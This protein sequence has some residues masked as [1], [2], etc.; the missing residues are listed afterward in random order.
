MNRY[1]VTSGVLGVSAGARVQLTPD[2]AAPRA[3]RL[4]PVDGEKD[5]FVAR[6]VLQFKTG[7][8]LGVSEIAK[9]QAGQVELLDEPK[10]RRA[11]PDALV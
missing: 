8:V 5:V 10:P 1:K 6:D 11:K 2:Q 4:A 9:G 7:E 3:H